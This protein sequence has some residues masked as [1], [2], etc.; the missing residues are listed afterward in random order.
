MQPQNCADLRT[1]S[2]GEKEGSELD[3]FSDKAF[4]AE[5]ASDALCDMVKSGIIQ[6]N[7]DGTVN[8]T[9]NATR[10]EAAVVMHRI[11]N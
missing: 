6:G 2:E 8:P 5:Y 10:A 3:V 7:A 1:K 11:M 9:G 4:V